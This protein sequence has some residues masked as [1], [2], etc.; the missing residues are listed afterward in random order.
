MNMYL[1]L[2]DSPPLTLSFKQTMHGDR[3]Q[4]TSSRMMEYKCTTWPSNDKTKHPNI[5]FRFFPKMIKGYSPS[6][7][8]T[9]SSSLCFHWN[10][11]HG[12][13]YVVF[14]TK[15]EPMYRLPLKL[16]HSHP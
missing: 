9:H 15:V 6:L 14:D 10:N 5:M 8:Y 13:S 1:I 4:L 11:N 12:N 2:S 3:T 16:Y 7:I